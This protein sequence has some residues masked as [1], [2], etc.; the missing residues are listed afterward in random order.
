MGKT[1]HD[2]CHSALGMPPGQ[3]RIDLELAKSKTF[4]FPDRLCPGNWFVR[5]SKDV[6]TSFLSEPRQIRNVIGVCMRKENELHIQFMVPG[7]AHHF[8]RIASSIERRGGATRRVPDQIRVDGHVVIVRVEL[9]DAIGFINF[10]GMPLAPGEFI[11][12]SRSKTKN[13]R[14]A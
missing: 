2:V 4:S 10:L 9:R 5:G 1:R 6:A 14:N 13:T 12:W 11:K 3:P 8:A 7:K